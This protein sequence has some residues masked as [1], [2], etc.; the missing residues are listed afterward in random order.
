MRFRHM[1]FRRTCLCVALSVAGWLVLLPDSAE[2]QPGRVVAQAAINQYLNGYGGPGVYGG[3]NYYQPRYYG[4]YAVPGVTVYS[5]PGIAVGTVYSNNVYP[6][7]PV[8]GTYYPGVAGGY[9]Y[10]PGGYPIYGYRNGG[11]GYGYSGG[12]PAYQYG[13]SGIGVGIGVY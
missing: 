6:S 13:N 1:Y 7:G 9:G 2:S 12:Y 5:N 10:A 11:Y 8:P 4:G 3:Y